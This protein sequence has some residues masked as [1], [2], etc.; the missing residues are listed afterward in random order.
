MGKAKTR[1]ADA[2]D[3][4]EQSARLS[5]ALS[6]RAPLI[7]A[8]TRTD[9]CMHA[10]THVQARCHQMQIQTRPMW[11]FCG[12]MRTRGMWLVHPPLCKHNTETHNVYSVCTVTAVLSF[13]QAICCVTVV[14]G[15]RV[16]CTGYLLSPYV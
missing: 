6:P 9:T 11:Q 2:V 16:Q 1:A 14:V 3:A 7:S 4:G 12:Q 8:H 10:C 5:L 13:I 15:A